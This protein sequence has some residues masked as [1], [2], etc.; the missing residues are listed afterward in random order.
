M[1]FSEYDAYDGVGLAELVRKKEVKPE[2]LLDEAIA[3]A[4]KVNPK[5]NAIVHFAREQA[6]EQ[7]AEIDLNGS[8]A[9]VPFLAKDLGATVKGMP[10]TWGSRAYKGLVAKHDSLYFERAK[11]AGLVVFGKTNIPEF[12][13][14][15]IT[16]PKLFG[17]CRNPWNPDHTPGGSSG[18]AASAVAAGIVHLAHASDGGGSIRCPASCTGLFGLK[19]SRGRNPIGPNRPDA[20]GYL[21]VEH[22][23]SKSIRDSA[24]LLDATHGRDPFLGWAAPPPDRSFLEQMSREPGR[25]KI[26]IFRGAMLGSKVD[27]ECTAALNHTAKLLENLGHHVED[28]EP[29]D[30]DYTDVAKNF[31]MIWSG[32]AATV[33]DWLEQ[34]KG[35]R[36]KP[37]EFEPATWG[38]IKAAGILKNWDIAKAIEEQGNLTRKVAAFFSE[39]DLMLSPTL[40]GPPVKVGQLYPTP[41]DELTILS[42]V[43]TGNADLMRKTIESLAKKSFGWVSFCA[44]FNMTGQPAA[45]IPTYWSK[46]GLP[47][48]TQLVARY[49]EEG[50]LFQVAA[51]LEK[52]QPW[53]SRRPMI[54]AG[55]EEKAGVIA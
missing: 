49:G 10:I 32:V 11:K 20:V 35:V 21:T 8:F 51:Q 44:T 4:E 30:I 45:S 28:A 31:L 25:K 52:A 27:P 48:G 55:Q 19:P 24:A 42:I 37:S 1:G 53:A 14:L 43:A 41:I 6:K 3:R 29:K 16:E 36:S 33:H 12:G 9:G 40:S 15:P 38:M 23:I 26:A 54:F 22:G 18:G 17:A 7:L 2:E 39:Y 47:I 5:L 50:L 46:D 13:Q 34:D